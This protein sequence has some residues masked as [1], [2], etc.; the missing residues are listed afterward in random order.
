MVGIQLENREIMFSR[1]GRLVELLRVNVC[2]REM[3]AY[4]VRIL[5]EERAQFVG[6]VCGIIR[7]TQRERE[8]KAC[9]P[10]RWLRSQSQFVRGE[11]ER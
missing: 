3:R 6:C 7:I 9:V 8:I 10:G 1:E 11:G 4:L 5:G 2:D